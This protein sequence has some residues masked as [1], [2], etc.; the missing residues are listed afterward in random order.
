MSGDGLELRAGNSVGSDKFLPRV[1]ELS[2]GTGAPCRRVCFLVKSL[3]LVFLGVYILEELCSCCGSE[4]FFLVAKVA[5]VELELEAWTRVFACVVFI[6][7]FSCYGSC[8]VESWIFDAWRGEVFALCTAL[9]EVLDLHGIWN[10]GC[11]PG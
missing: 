9:V 7:L 2:R 1:Q 4:S 3:L 8:S 11:R 10:H 5:H 6:L